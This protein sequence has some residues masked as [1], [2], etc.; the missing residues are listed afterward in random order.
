MCQIDSKIGLKY[1]D[2]DDWLDVT[3]DADLER[4]YQENKEKIK[5]KIDRDPVKMVAKAPA[6]SEVPKFKKMVQY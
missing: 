3:T 6:G 4:C 2:G 5:F 1:Q